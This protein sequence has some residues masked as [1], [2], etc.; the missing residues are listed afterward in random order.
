[1][2]EQS[3]VLVPGG[4]LPAGQPDQPGSAERAPHTA[5]AVASADENQISNQSTTTSKDQRIAAAA[6]KLFFL[7]SRDLIGTDVVDRDNSGH[8]LGRVASIIIDQATDRAVY[9]TLEWGG[10]LGW[11]K[12]R[13]LLP[14]EIVSFSGQWDRPTLRVPASKVENAPQFHEGDL[15]DVLRDPEWRRAVAQY[16]GVAEPGTGTTANADVR[17][18]QGRREETSLPQSEQGGPQRSDINVIRGLAGVS[19]S[20]ATELAA[21][22]EQGQGSTGPTS[23]STSTAPSGSLVES[24]SSASAGGAPDPQHG[25]AIAKHSCAACH[26]F[27]QGGPTRVGPNLFGVAR[28]PVASVP[29]YNYSPALKGHRG[30]WDGASLNA[31]LKSP[32]GYAPGTYMTFAGINSD[33]DRQDL[34]SFLEG[35]NAGAAQ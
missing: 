5:A 16:F 30:N 3:S 29:G 32:R 2:H 21:K 7:S 20:T 15:D 24:A 23:G 31:F 19:K 35:L 26:T 13:I 4:G 18:E 9:L 22:S 10:F 28:R 1:M 17:V 6:D 25:Q 27:N 8:T 12:N 11:D 33:Q 34:I 14:F